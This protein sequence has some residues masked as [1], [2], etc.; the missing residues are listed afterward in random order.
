MTYIIIL[1]VTKFGEDALNR[2]WDIQQKPSEGR[3]LPPPQE[4]EEEFN[5]S[6]HQQKSIKWA[7]FLNT[8]R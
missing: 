3:I 4:E 5:A 6:F 2:F 1:K 8:D 7:Y